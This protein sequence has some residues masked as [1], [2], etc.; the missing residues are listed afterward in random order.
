M[1]IWEHLRLFLAI[2]N[3]TCLSSLESSPL[4]VTCLLPFGFYSLSCRSMYQ[5]LVSCLEKSV[6]ILTISMAFNNL[7]QFHPM[8][9]KRVLLVMETNLS[10]SASVGFSSLSLA[11]T[12]SHGHPLLQKQGKEESSF[13]TS[14]PRGSSISGKENQGKGCWSEAQVSSTPQRMALWWDKQMKQTYFTHVVFSRTSQKP[15]MEMEAR[16]TSAL[17]RRWELVTAW[18]S[19]PLDSNNSMIQFTP[20][21]PY[22]IK[23]ESWGNHTLHTLRWV[24]LF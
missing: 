19:L 9:E 3:D 23:W 4:V 6:I 22:D 7:T 24:W 14:V 18:K 17:S 2:K 8:T 13:E 1:T 11:R 15:S 16:Y 20:G 21:Q 5:Y 10:L 12:R